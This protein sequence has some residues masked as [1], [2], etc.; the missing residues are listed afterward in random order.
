METFSWETFV[1]TGD[2]DAYLLY[3]SVEQLK[4]EDKEE[5]QWQTSEQQ[6]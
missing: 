6:A 4:Q 1:Q 2:I 3:K 5:A